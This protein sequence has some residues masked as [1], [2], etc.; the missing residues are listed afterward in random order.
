M[1]PCCC[2]GEITENP[3]CD[4]C[5]QPW[6]G[7]D[8]IR[9]VVRVVT[10]GIDNCACGSGVNIVA[11][12]EVGGGA[13]AGG[14]G[15]DYV[16]AGPCNTCLASSP[17][18]YSSNSCGITRLR[19][20]SIDWPNNFQSAGGCEVDTGE[21]VCL[22]LFCEFCP[23]GLP[24]DQTFPAQVH[25]LEVRGCT[26]HPPCEG[27]PVLPPCVGFGNPNG[28]DLHP[29]FCGSRG[30]GQ[31]LD[32]IGDGVISIRIHRCVMPGTCN[33]GN[34]GFD[35]VPVNSGPNGKKY[36]AVVV[37]FVGPDVTYFTQEIRCDCGGQGC[38]LV[39]DTLGPYMGVP[40][41]WRC[42]YAA[43]Q[44]ACDWFARGTYKLVGYL[45]TGCVG[46]YKI[47][48]VQETA[49]CDIEECSCPCFLEDCDWEN[50]VSTAEMCS[51]WKPPSQ[52]TVTR[53]Q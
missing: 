43:P 47:A 34:P 46:S 9:H 4:P 18:A 20:R 14:C 22:P 37:E 10:S 33:I 12:E 6:E 5:P 21:T 8:D 44:N 30:Q 27:D 39:C 13:F 52:I 7:F 15:L 29:D 19:M 40:Q 48:D 3:H 2:G 16:P 51:S 45:T 32:D 50:G 42:V 41:Y 1:N 17:L 28:C 23:P 53:L 36:S 25:T 38:E 31:F 35:C 24:P 49:L 11:G 26:A